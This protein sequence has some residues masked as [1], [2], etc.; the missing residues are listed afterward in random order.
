MKDSQGKPILF[1]WLG[2]ARIPP[3]PPDET[4]GDPA[5]F[6]D[7]VK[8][9]RISQARLRL[10]K[11]ELPIEADRNR[12]AMKRI[13]LFSHLRRFGLEVDISLN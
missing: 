2:D 5:W 7:Q 13:Q 3:L 12:E 4:K 9:S 11:P 1:Y 8:D 10:I 6:E